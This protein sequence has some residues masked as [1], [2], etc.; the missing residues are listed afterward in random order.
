[1]FVDI[2]DTIEAKNEATK[3]HVSQF[4]SDV[5]DWIRSWAAR[6]GESRGVAYAEEFRRYGISRMAA[7][8]GD[9]DD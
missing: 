1:M 5:Q 8:G 2:S 9:W 6:N 7:D 4:G 3:L